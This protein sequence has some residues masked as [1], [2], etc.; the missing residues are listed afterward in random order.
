MKRRRRKNPEGVPYPYGNIAAG[1]LAGL[2]CATGG[3]L[4]DAPYEGF[5]PDTYVRSIWIGALAGAVTAAFTRDPLIA[6]MCAGYMERAAVEGWKIIRKQRPGKFDYPQ[7]DP[8]GAAAPRPW[9]QA[10]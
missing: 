8:R 4:K 3:A 5:Q 7:T 6:F 1:L 2:L 10:A 9:L